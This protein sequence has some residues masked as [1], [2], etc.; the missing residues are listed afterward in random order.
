M[1]V[2]MRMNEKEKGLKIRFHDLYVISYFKRKVKAPA[3]AVRENFNFMEAPH[4]F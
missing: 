4:T 3:C 1:S 2:R